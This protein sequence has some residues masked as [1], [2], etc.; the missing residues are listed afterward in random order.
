MGLD[1]DEL[2]REA[3]TRL[4]SGVAV[5]TARRP[6]GLP[7]GIAATSLTSYSAHPPSLL[8]C[9]WHASRCH[10]PIA[11]CDHFGVHLLRTNEIEVAHAFADRESPDK[12]AGLEWRWDGDVPE[13]TGTLAYLRCRRAENFVRYD[14]TIVIGDLQGG[15][16]EPGE[17]LVYARRRMDWLMQPMQ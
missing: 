5:I 10:A 8:V 6:D 13:L 3:M 15:R 1:L 14:H 11:A 9:V 7:C 17:P 16:I 4:A 2:F 12:F